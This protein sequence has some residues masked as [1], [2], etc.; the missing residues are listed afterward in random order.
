MNSM[1]NQLL[2]PAYCVRK[3][4]SSGRCLIDH[5]FISIKSWVLEVKQGLSSEHSYGF[6]SFSIN[7]EVGKVIKIETCKYFAKSTRIMR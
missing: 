1:K 5:I 3:R 6:I 2:L 4:A 7:M